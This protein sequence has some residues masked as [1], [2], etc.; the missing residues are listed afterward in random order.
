MRAVVSISLD[1]Q[2]AADLHREA[3]QRGETFSEYV[4]TLLDLARAVE[5]V[6]EQRLAERRP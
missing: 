3:E 5:T 1:P 4:R 6:M 2:V